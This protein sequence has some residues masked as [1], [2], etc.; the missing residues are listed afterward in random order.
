MGNVVPTAAGTGPQ[1]DVHVVLQGQLPEYLPVEQ[2]G[3]GKFMK[4][5]LCKHVPRADGWSGG[6]GTSSGSAT[7]GRSN[8]YADEKAVVKV[9]FKRGDKSAELSR[10][11]T[12]AREQLATLARTF[13]LARQPNIVPYQWFHDSAKADAAFLGRQ[14]FQ[15]SLHDRL[16]TRPFLSYNEKLWVIY[17]LIRAVAQAHAAGVVHGDIKAEN[18]LVTSWGWVLLADF[19]VFKPAYV[20]EDHPSDF[21]YYFEAGSRRRCYIAP[22]RFVKEKEL[23]QLLAPQAGGGGPSLASQASSA[24]LLSGA[25]AVSLSGASPAF[26]ALRPAPS[27][28]GMSLAG[29]AAGGGSSSAPTPSLGSRPTPAAT[30]IFNPAS[31]ISQAASLLE[32]GAAGSATASSEAAAGSSTSSTGMRTS[33]DIFALGCVIAEVLL[34]G[35]ALF[36]LPSLLKYRAATATES[37]AGAADGAAGASAPAS[38]S[39]AAAASSSAPAF[40]PLSQEGIGEDLRKADPSGALR[41]MIGHMIQRNPLKRG[42]AQQ[43]LD[44]FTCVLQGGGVAGATA[45]VGTV[46][47]RNLFPSYFPALHSLMV[48]MLRPSLQSP[49]ARVTAVLARYPHL[50]RL[51]CSPGDSN[52]LSSE[53]LFDPAGEAYFRHRLAAEP[54]RVVV[55]ACRPIPGWPSVIPPTAMSL[56]SNIS[57]SGGV[58]ATTTSVPDITAA[59]TS[60]SRYISASNSAG[61]GSGIISGPSRY[62]FGSQKAVGAI[63]GLAWEWGWVPGAQWIGSEASGAFSSGGADGCGGELSAIHRRWT[64]FQVAKKA[65]SSSDVAMAST[66]AAPRQQR[67]SSVIVN[68]TASPATAAAAAADRLSSLLAEADALLAALGGDLGGSGLT[69][70]TVVTTIEGS[71]TV[72]ALTSCAAQLQLGTEPPA[73]RRGDSTLSTVSGTSTLTSAAAVTG[74]ARPSG[75]Q[76]GYELVPSSPDAAGTDGNN[77][78]GFIVALLTACLRSVSTPRL[79]LTAVQLISRLAAITDDECRLQRVL[80]YMVSLLGDTSAPVRAHALCALSCALEAVAEFPPTDAAIISHYV[81]PQ[82]QKLVGDPEPLVQLAAAECLPS[83]AV[84]ARRI[85]DLAAWKEQLEAMKKAVTS[86]AAAPPSA[87]NGASTPSVATPDGASLTSP[88]SSSLSS[89]SPG[90]VGA[91]GFPSAAAVSS[92]LKIRSSY[93]AELDASQRRLQAL[94]QRWVF[95]QGSTAS[96]TAAL[97]SFGESLSRAVPRNVPPSVAHSLLSLPVAGSARKG[98]QRASASHSSPPPLLDVSPLTS[99]AELLAQLPLTSDTSLVKRVMLQRSKDLCDFFGRRGTDEFVL[100]LLMTFLQDP[101]HGEALKSA[102]NAIV[103]RL[104]AAVAGQAASITGAGSSDGAAPVVTSS[105]TSLL[106]SWLN[107]SQMGTSDWLLRAAFV[108]QLVLLSPYVGAYN[109]Q[110]SLLPLIEQVVSDSHEQ[111][112]HKALIGLA[113]LAR[114]QLVAP[115]V[116]LGHV[117]KYAPLALHP[118]GWIRSGAA[119]LVATVWALQGAGAAYV[120]SSR[121]VNGLLREGAG[122]VMWQKVEQLL[123]KSTNGSDA[124]FGVLVAS[125]RRELMAASLQPL[126]RAE[127]DTEAHRVALT[128]MQSA[129]PALA[130]RLHAMT[131]NAGKRH[132]ASLIANAIASNASGSDSEQADA[133][134]AGSGTDVSDGEDDGISQ[135]PSPSMRHANYIQPSVLS[136]DAILSSLPSQAASGG[137]LL[138]AGGA[139]YAPPFTAPADRVRYTKGLLASYIS[140]VA[141]PCRLSLPCSQRCVDNDGKTAVSPEVAALDS[142]ALLAIP[143]AV[144]EVAPLPLHSLSVPDQRYASVHPT[145][146][147]GAQPRC[148]NPQDDVSARTSL[149]QLLPAD[150]D[151]GVF[152]GSGAAPTTALPVVAV[153]GTSSSINSAKH[154]PAVVDA[155]LS[156]HVPAWHYATEATAPLARDAHAYIRALAVLS[157]TGQLVAALPGNGAAAIK[158]SSGWARGERLSLPLTLALAGGAVNP[159]FPLLS[160][161]S[162]DGVAM[163]PYQPTPAK[164]LALLRRDWRRAGRLARKLHLRH[165]IWDP[166]L[167]ADA[168]VAAQAAATGVGLATA[169]YYGKGGVRDDPSLYPSD[170]E[171]DTAPSAVAAITDGPGTIISPLLRAGST[172]AGLGSPALTSS[173]SMLPPTVPS[174]VSAAV[175]TRGYRTASFASPPVP[176]PSA[177]S[178][179][180]PSGGSAEGRSGSIVASVNASRTPSYLAAHPQGTRA[181]GASGTGTADSAADATGSMLREVDAAIN[182]DL[183]VAQPQV[184]SQPPAAGGAASPLDL[185]DEDADDTP[186]NDALG[187]GPGAADVSGGGDGIGTGRS[188]PGVG[189]GPTSASN[190][191]VMDVVIGSS[192]SNDTRSFPSVASSRYIGAAHAAIQ[193]SDAGGLLVRMIRLQAGVGA[194]AAAAG[195][196]AVGAAAGMPPTAGAAG[197]AGTPLAS[198]GPAGSGAAAFGATA[199]GRRAAMA[200]RYDVLNTQQREKRARI[201]E[202]GPRGRP[203]LRLSG[204]YSASSSLG[205]SVGYD[206]S[207]ASQGN[208]VTSAGGGGLMGGQS[209]QQQMGGGATNAPGGS[210]RSASQPAAAGGKRGAVPTSG[211]AAAAQSLTS[212]SLL[213]QSA[214]GLSSGTT[215]AA[216]MVEDASCVSALKEAEEVV[217]KSAAFRLPAKAGGAAGAGKGGA[218]AAAAGSSGT[219]LGARIIEQPAPSANTAAPASAAAGSASG[220]S[221]SSS[222]SSAPGSGSLTIIPQYT[223]GQ[224]QG[225]SA[226]AAARG[227]AA[228]VPAASSSSASAAPT[229]RRASTFVGSATST[230]TSSASSGVPSSSPTASSAAGRSAKAAISTAAAG[231][232]AVIISTSDDR[233]YAS[234]DIAE[235]LARRIAA[236]E[237]PPLPP[238]L[239]SLQKL[240]EPPAT[241]IAHAVRV[242]SGVVPQP[243]ALSSAA[244]GVG[245]GAPSSVNAGMNATIQAIEAA[246]EVILTAPSAAGTVATVASPLLLNGAILDEAPRAG[247]TDSSATTTTSAAA[248]SGQMAATSSSIDAAEAAV[249]MVALTS[250]LA[251]SATASSDVTAA[252]ADGSSAMPVPCSIPLVP[253]PIHPPQSDDIVRPSDVGDGSGYVG[254]GRVSFMGVERG[255]ADGVGVG[256]PHGAP[257][258][259]TYGM[260]SEPPALPTAD[261]AS[262]GSRGDQD[263]VAAEG[264]GTRGAQLVSISTSAGSSGGSGLTSSG[265]QPLTSSSS[266]GAQTSVGPASGSGVAGGGREGAGG[267]SWDGG[268]GTNGSRPRG[269]LLCTASEHAAA[270]TALAVCQDHSFFASGSADGTVKIWSTKGID[271]EVTYVSSLTYTGHLQ[272]ARYGDVSRGISVGLRNNAVTDAIV[273]DNSTSVAS[274]SSA[275]TVHVWRVDLPAASRA[276]ARAGGGGA[277]ASS[278]GY[279]P[280]SIA[281]PADYVGTASSGGGYYSLSVA[282]GDDGRDG[283]SRRKGTYGSHIG[284][285]A[286][287]VEAIAGR[288]ASSASSSSRGGAGSASNAGSVATSTLKSPEGIAVVRRLVFDPCE[289]PVAAVRHYESSTQSVLAVATANGVLHGCDLR[290]RTEAWAVRLPSALGRITALEMCPGST[291]AIVGTE[292]GIIALVDL[293]FSL[294][295]CAWRHSARQPINAL[296]PY[297]TLGT[298]PPTDGN[299][300]S[301]VEGAGSSSGTGSFRLHPHAMPRGVAQIALCRQLAVGVATGEGDVSFWSLETGTCLRILRSLPDAVSTSDATRLPFLRRI[302][303]VGGKVAAGDVIELNRSATS[304]AALT[305]AAGEALRHDASYQPAPRAVRALLCPLPTSQSSSAAQRLMGGALGSGGG[306]GPGGGAGGGGPAGDGSGADALSA[307][308]FAEFLTSGRRMNDPSS[309][310]SGSGAGGSA[311]GPGGGP[312]G[313]AAASQSGVGFVLGG[314]R[315]A[316]AVRRRGGYAVGYAVGTGSGSRDGYAA[317]TG[318]TELDAMGGSGDVIFSY[319][320]NQSEG[321]PVWMVTAGSDRIVRCWDLDRPRASHTVCGLEPGHVRDGYEGSV[322]QA[323]APRQW[324]V[325]LDAEGDSSSAPEPDIDDEEEEDDEDDVDGQHFAAH[326]SPDGVS[327]P[328]VGFSRRDGSAGKRQRE[329][330]SSGSETA[331]LSR[332]EREGLRYPYG[333]QA[334]HPVRMALSQPLYDPSKE[335]DVMGGSSGVPPNPSVLMRGPVP[336]STAHNGAITSLAWLDVPTRLLLTGSEDGHVRIWR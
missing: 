274:A 259:A 174:S 151:A 53:G 21:Y 12:L 85:L 50:L 27:V 108:D 5:L 138:A 200:A 127:F 86:A 45:A 79:K 320:A 116:S 154:S 11:I 29:A 175:T 249:G 247:E 14:H 61:S 186:H 75:Q 246:A 235:S 300:L 109:T 206:P 63:G 306:G 308:E 241:I 144:D 28:V 225:G 78:I 34:D 257:L 44:A 37:G 33:M 324:Q 314:M 202:R 87:N 288:P 3:R 120:T 36:D 167:P 238:N 101:L 93:D 156:A 18:F 118:S 94:L 162:P 145:P 330:R 228:S 332:R 165:G 231:S 67:P 325:E 315:G 164:L 292:R 169:F 43:Y 250:A 135:P 32:G 262:S 111:V 95:G 82:V 143:Y 209:M 321:L 150:G 177:G 334:P 310:A 103:P 77:G 223:G 212:S 173:S 80:P 230:A 124:A 185:D 168:A 276:A 184:A 333:H 39:S 261:Y 129:S 10:R 119:T 198:G 180:A 327:R 190:V 216:V 30:G 270:V 193:A 208:V 271:R 251:T 163:L 304:A 139:P 158:R 71:A 123:A 183:S 1:Q 331:H 171:T 97:A 72:T 272:E 38:S 176:A 189:D 296:Y 58:G 290:A 88:S 76:E 8:V 48:S 102:G 236:L 126:T 142:S 281:P 273:C 161:P 213:Q 59:L 83:L 60:V 70:A 291:S 146:P 234:P 114:T 155:V 64:P 113:Q 66:A 41:E 326:F 99:F 89:S 7:S 160:S 55:D 265:Q 254:A 329:S 309:S 182:G 294:L 52:A 147:R 307:K 287:A 211:P 313:S 279:T 289:G 222:S 195:A 203:V 140:S 22:E 54:E 46:P 194:S 149:A 157:S 197:S 239:G 305:S 152:V 16:N 205:P 243:D 121:H 153:D 285:G 214:I 17:Q 201:G 100:P 159:P 196:G 24:A 258:A 2:L 233:D 105:L 224:G 192:G 302:T 229:I 207:M 283:D 293:R 122:D 219:I 263:G 137:A 23:A 134:G 130:A 92:G 311:S 170:D 269:L 81:L 166:L 84:T 115:S 13:S 280:S 98:G 282:G 264:Q 317:T 181:R 40:D 6:G 312:A 253:V 132:M 73:R 133:S 191:G 295:L 90:A 221:S 68:A 25:S 56:P 298:R 69:A 104:L 245:G 255:W 242:A 74:A 107:R 277:A 286:E 136:T 336:A 299:H 210:G 65:A 297:V 215:S 316:G 318:G 62:A 106:M 96:Q 232:A 131:S 112:A 227:P 226:T 244:P 42:S 204:A 47:V 117:Q 57:S 4:T 91:D 323:Y 128:A 110:Y 49:D 319:G 240:S 172:I 199:G 322:L 141:G 248:K 252:S 15:Y 218:M 217:Q 26:T 220:S 275:G 278:V 335:S 31:E 284:S 268:D 9:F 125:L 237:L 20:P 19:G 256:A 188:S 301:P 51:L 267:I 266:P 35:E 260:T 178:A 187:D 179:A 328:R 148:P 303:V